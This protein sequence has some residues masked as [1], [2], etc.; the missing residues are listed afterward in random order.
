MPVVFVIGKDWTFRTGVR[1]ELR[2]RGIEALGMESPD[3]AGRAIAAGTVP[4]AIVWDTSG[5]ESPSATEQ[6]SNH[7]PLEFLGICVPLLV[8]ASHMEGSALPANAACVLY[9]PVLVGDIVQRVQQL[10][11]GQAA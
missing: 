4:G 2:E 6:T 9:R 3:E 1:A 8:V 5:R 10:L 11:E 7:G